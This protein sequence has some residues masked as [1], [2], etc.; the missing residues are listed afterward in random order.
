MSR[1]IRILVAKAGLDGHDRGA[2]VVAA[3]LRDAGMEVIYT[4]LHQTPEQIAEAAVQEDVEVVGISSL[5]GA[6]MTLFTRVLELLKEAGAGHIMVVGGGI[7][8]E[9]DIVGLEKRGV[10]KLFGPGT[11][12]PVIVDWIVKAVD[13]QRAEA[14]KE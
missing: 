13:A 4:G 1:P 11:E 8:S 6:H 12:L 10:A 2:K 3:G 7:I 14:A 5:A 9:D